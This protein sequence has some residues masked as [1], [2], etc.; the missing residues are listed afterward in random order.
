[1]IKR[2]VLGTFAAG[3]LAACGGTDPDVVDTQTSNVAPSESTSSEAA[4]PQGTIL[5]S[6]FGQSGQYAW[7]IALVQNE[8][9]H[10]GQTVTVNFNVKD[11]SGH[12]IASGAQVA[13]F[14]WVGQ[15]LPVATQVDLGRHA[16]AASLEATVLVEDEGTFDDEVVDND[17]GTFSGTL[18]QQYGSWGAK[19]EV[20]NPTSEPLTGSAV[21][22]ICHDASGKIIGGSSSYPELIPPSGE[23]LVDVSDLYTDAK[24]NDCLGYL[25]PWM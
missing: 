20:K 5:E 23:T 18:Y 12:L 7:V 11:A 22:V 13:A 17:W 25:H 21:E 1:M 3:V 2:I 8:S 24:P 9:D 6:G 19:F 16:K 14:N 10:A 15:K 4:A